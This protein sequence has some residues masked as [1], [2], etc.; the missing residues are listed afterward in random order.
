MDPFILLL[1]QL[2]TLVSNN[3][4]TLT[5]LVVAFLGYLAYKKTNLQTL[6]HRTSLA[7]RVEKI[8]KEIQTP[9]LSYTDLK[10]EVAERSSVREVLKKL[11]SNA[12]ANRAYLFKFH[13][14]TKYYT[15]KHQTRCTCEV[16][17]V[18]GGTTPIMALYQNVPVH[19][20]P[21][22]LDKLLEGEA[23]VTKV[24]DIPQEFTIEKNMY[25]K[26]DTKAIATIPIPDPDSGLL[27]GFIGVSWTTKRTKKGETLFPFMENAATDIQSIINL[28]EDDS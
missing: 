4:D 16:E 3:S 13:N 26:S 22:I 18:S 10:K 7:D 11:L 24:K 25:Q 9:T 19:G 28:P 5:T 14:G 20:H 17:V 2:A 23:A 15:N 21:F 8:E 6:E 12:G 27:I 1:K